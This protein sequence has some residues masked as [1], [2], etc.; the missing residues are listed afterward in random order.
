MKHKN[1]GFTLIEIMVV[2]VILGI[3]AAIAIPSYN[4][5]IER[6]RIATA[7][8]KLQENAVILGKLFMRKN[9]YGDAVAALASSPN[10]DDYFDYSV[11]I[12]S[13]SQEYMLVAKSN[14]DIKKNIFFT[15]LGETFICPKNITASADANP[16]NCESK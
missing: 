6:S 9:S 2:V 7:R 13:N 3:I 10:S 8:A 5:Y 12:Y 14:S 4:N 11:D 15:K 1:T 16:T